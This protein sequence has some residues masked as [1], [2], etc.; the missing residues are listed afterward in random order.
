M[1]QTKDSYIDFQCRNDV[2]EKQFNFS[3][4]AAIDFGYA[5]A[6]ADRKAKD[7]AEFTQIFKACT[8][9]PEP[10]QGFSTVGMGDK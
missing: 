7:T 10:T 6:V 8:R 9:K 2:L 3:Y 4:Q 1:S 5:K